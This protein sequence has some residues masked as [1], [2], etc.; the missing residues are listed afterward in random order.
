M[1]GGFVINLGGLHLLLDDVS[2]LAGPLF[3]QFLTILACIIIGFERVRQ[4]RN[5]FLMILRDDIKTQQL[6]DLTN[7]LIDLSETDELTGL[8]N[9]RRLYS[10]IPEI[11]KRANNVEGWLKVIMIDVDNFKSFND[12]AGHLAGDQC[13]KKVAFALARRTDESRQFIARYGG[14]EFVVVA[15]T[16]S[17]EEGEAFTETLRRSVEELA[18]P[19]PASPTGSPVTISAGIVQIKADN[20]A[21]NRTLFAVA[22]MALYDA[23]ENGRNR[24]CKRDVSAMD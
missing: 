12:T 13:L 23:K 4:S 15:V 8:K 3:F 17:I 9:R 5:R 16:D 18:Q 14:E 21:G 22:D 6:T 10:A 7:T 1:I 11:R 20:P 2:Q 24:V 19:H